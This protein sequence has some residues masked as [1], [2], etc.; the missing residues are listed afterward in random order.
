MFLCVCVQD[1]VEDHLR[2]TLTQLKLEY[3]DLFLIHWPVTGVEAE[4]VTPPLSDTWKGMEAVLAKGL[5]KAIGVSNYGIKKLEDMQS[6]ATVMPVVNQVEMH[7]LCRQDDLVS[8]CAALGIHV[9]AYSPLGT[10]DSAEML[11]RTGPALLDHPTIVK[12]AEESGHSPGQVLIRWGLQRGTSV[13]PKSV[14]PSRIEQN[15]DMFTWELSAEHMQILSSM[16]PQERMLDG[17]FNTK[18]GGPYRTVEE[19]WA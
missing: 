2:D 18:P 9:T 1:V 3:V 15:F 13:I 6:Y 10:P 8:R 4:T 7:P 19:L 5:T 11:K 16:E 12:I 14:T 17:T